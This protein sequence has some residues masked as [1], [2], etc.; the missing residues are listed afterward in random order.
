MNI[1]SLLIGILVFSGIALGL[2]AYYGD[3]IT[4]YNPDNSTSTEEFQKFNQTFYDYN[5]KISSIENKTSLF[6]IKDPTSWGDG[7]LAFLGV[8]GII[9]DT[10]GMFTSTIQ[11]MLTSTGIPIPAWFLIIIV[12]GVMLFVM[13]KVASIFLRKQ[14]G[15]I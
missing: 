5:E 1:T 11:N 10:P 14:G 7:T 3:I 12:S 9:I 6:N 13:M 15:D 8:V 4:V 2:V